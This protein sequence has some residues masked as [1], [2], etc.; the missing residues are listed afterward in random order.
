MSRRGED[1]N[2]QA[3]SICIKVHL[4]G[5]ETIVAACDANL[6]GETLK[7][8]DYDFH[9]TKDFYD[10]IRTNETI[11]KEHLKRATIANLVGN[12]C[13]KCGVEIGII[14]DENILYIKGVPHAQFTVMS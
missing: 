13:V 10:E 2:S 5:S 8:D 14:T 11:L 1:T 9:I 7:G 4:V 12:N 6:L 3:T